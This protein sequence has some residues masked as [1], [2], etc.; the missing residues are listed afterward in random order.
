MNNDVQA[1]DQHLDEYHTG[2]VTLL[3]LLWGEGFLSPGGEA[4]VDA[5]V[6]Q[7]DLNGQ[8]VLDIGCALGGCD[9]VLARKYGA[10]V[11]GLDV[12]APLIEQGRQRVAAAGRSDQI[13]LRL[14]QPG[15]LPLAGAAVD[16]V[17]GKDSW[18]HIED[19][20]GFFAEVY[21]V[22]KPGGILTASDWLRSDQPYSEEM[23]YFFKMEGLTYNMDTLENYGAILRDTGFVE[24][25]LVDTSPEYSHP[26]PRGVPAHAGTSRRH[27]GRATGR[28]AGRL[29]R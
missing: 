23:L 22:L 20:R 7:L 11:I 24:V 1:N 16:V 26:G 5:I 15:P 25:R 21:R 29:L 13:D 18:I 19:K 3:E 8:T 14:T 12:E 2:L 4:A 28:R 9:L 6:A 17:F 10:Q 27:D